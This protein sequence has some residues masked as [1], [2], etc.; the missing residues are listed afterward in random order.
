MGRL[1]PARF[2]GPIQMRDPANQSSGKKREKDESTD[3]K[4]IE[5]NWSLLSAHEV[6]N[7]GA[8]YHRKVNDGALAG[9]VSYADRLR[10]PET[11]SGGNRDYG[12]VAEHECN[13]EWT[14]GRLSDSLWIPGWAAGSL[15][16]R[17]SANANMWQL[18]R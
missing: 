10:F 9:R 5:Q 4:N 8:Q 12:A 14:P 3:F 1:S 13:S 17:P 18:R 15:L 16:G 11:N 6:K 2:F 7:R